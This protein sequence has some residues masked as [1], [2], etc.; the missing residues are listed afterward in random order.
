M[1]GQDTT[2]SD[3][4]PEPEGS[5]PLSSATRY[6]ASNLAVWK[7][8]PTLAAKAEFFMRWL[9]RNNLLLALTA[10][11]LALAL[12]V[13]LTLD[14]RA[15]LDSRWHHQAPQVPIRLTPLIGHLETPP[16]VLS[17]DHY[18]SMWIELPRASRGPLTVS[19]VATLAE[20][21]E[22]RILFRTGPNTQ[23]RLPDG[24]GLSLRTNPTRRTEVIRRIDQRISRPEKCEGRER[25]FEKFENTEVRI[26]MEDG[27]I[28]F[29]L[30]GQIYRTCRLK[31]T[32]SAITFESDLRRL[33]IDD[34]LIRDGELWS[35]SDDFTHPFSGPLA[36]AILFG[37]TLACLQGIHRLE[38]WQYQRTGLEGEASRL[39]STL[40]YFP[41][42]VLPFV[43]ERDLKPIF[44]ALQL[45]LSEPKQTAVATAL[46]MTLTLKLV[47]HLSRPG[48]GRATPGEILADEPPTDR[49][50]PPPASEH[51]T[52]TPG[53]HRHHRSAVAFMVLLQTVL[54]A[55]LGGSHARWPTALIGGLV[56]PLFALGYHGRYSALKLQVPLRVEQMISG[57]YGFFLLAKF[58]NTAQEGRLML[59]LFTVGTSS[60]MAYVFVA[61]GLSLLMRLVSMNLNAR[62]IRGVNLVSLLLV[63][64]IAVCAEGAA[65]STYLEKSLD[66]EVAR[67]LMDEFHYLSFARE[68]R[69]Y[70][71]KYF[72]ASFD[73]RQPGTRVRIISLGGSSTAGAFQ[74]KNLK[75]FYPNQLQTMLSV[76]QGEGYEVINQGVGGWTTLHIQKYLASALSELDPDL[77]TLYVGH[78]DLLTPSAVPYRTLWE[79]FAQ[80]SLAS[81]SLQKFLNRI[82]VYVLLK[83]LLLLNPTEFESVA[84]PISDAKRNL[85]TIIEHAGTL[86]IPVLLMSEG[87]SPNPKPLEG[88]F[89]MMGKLAET[90]ENAYYLNTANF[91]WQT[92][93]GGVFLDDCHL[94]ER[95]HELLA[96]HILEY[97]EKTPRLLQP[98]GSTEP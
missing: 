63:V 86:Q 9:S 94:S 69:A 75:L 49:S 30:D 37:I 35:F 12:Q 56:L 72:P 98:R 62:E 71:D 21:S 48:V 73:P 6:T 91:L 46:G 28:T 80:Q 92:N 95:G 55:A 65:R 78:N 40:T 43:L 36:M 66:T 74:M 58:F 87:L 33:H 47:A 18:E 8:E 52:N 1:G 26:T 67:S 53:L 14:P 93:E 15:G 61:L 60:W 41:C 25:G 64:T 19:F 70:P 31:E 34:V 51:E 57:L 82:R 77:L 17:L 27:Q 5:L 68:H 11:V 24:Y 20:D 90:Y 13:L 97:L 42:W 39:L 22:L 50:A 54:L 44:D 38:V 4:M 83:E 84:I 23:E 7:L 3:Q 29:W 2:V 16:D 10:A 96:N 32:F 76:R 85:E 81:S 89:H 88:Y 59:E 45:S 79:Q